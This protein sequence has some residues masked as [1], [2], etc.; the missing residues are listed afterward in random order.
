VAWDGSEDASDI[1]DDGLDVDNDSSGGDLMLTI[2]SQ[3]NGL[4]RMGSSKS[5]TSRFLSD[6]FYLELEKP[7]SWDA[8]EAVAQCSGSTLRQFSVRIGTC[9]HAS[10]TVFSD[11][12]ALQTL[13]WRSESTI[14]NMTDTPSNG[15]PKLEE[16]GILQTS[17]SFLTAL[18]LMQY[19]F[20]D[21]SL[22]SNISQAEISPSCCAQQYHFCRHISQ[23]SWTQIDRTRA[24]VQ[25]TSGL[26]G[27]D[28]RSLPKSRVYFNLY[29]LDN[30]AS[31]H[32]IYNVRNA[33]CDQDDVP[34][35]DDFHAPQAVP[36]L[37]KIILNAPY[38]TRYVRKLPSSIPTELC[39]LGIRM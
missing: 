8:F 26:E 20:P 18:S 36:S 39:A 4:V 33:D 21:H 17:Q 7:I 6:S 22:C 9:L 35:V 12:T 23:G 16:L 38:W 28:I 1:A 10:A 37:V 3:T 15:F 19:V 32:L 24:S 11:L 14:I 29:A 2:L 31:Q 30:C 25:N 34:D 5:I 13:E 27:R